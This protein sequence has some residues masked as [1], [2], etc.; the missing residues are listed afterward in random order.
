MCNKWDQVPLDESDD[1]KKYVAKSLTRCLPHVDP[2]SRIIYISSANASVAQS[3]GII[4]EEFA[5]LVNGIKTM[6]LKRI[7]AKLQARWR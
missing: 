5:A 4:L 6:A 2:D 7:E 3:D 1:V